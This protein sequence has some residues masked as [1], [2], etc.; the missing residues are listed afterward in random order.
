MKGHDSGG[1]SK[2]YRST[3]I[4]WHRYL[5]HDYLDTF[6]KTSKATDRYIYQI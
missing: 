1:V 5:D 4:A 6:Y 2:V 3:D